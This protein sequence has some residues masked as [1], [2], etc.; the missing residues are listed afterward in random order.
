VTAANTVSTSSHE[1]LWV[2]L[3]ALLAASAVYFVRDLRRRATASHGDLREQ[4]QREE[5]LRE[6][7]KA[8]EGL[9]EMIVVVDRE[10]R[11]V[12]VNQAF[13]N[14]R[15]LEREQIIGRSVPEMVNRGVFETVIKEKLDECFRG[16]VV[17]F[18]MK[19]AYS[20]LGP[21]DLSLSYFPIEGPNGVERAVCVFQD[22]TERKRADQALHYLQDTLA[23]VRRI[24]ALGEL[25][26]SIAHEVNQPLA[27]VVTDNSAALHWLAAQPPNLDEARQALHRAIEEANRASGVIQRIRAL[28]R[29]APPQ[30]VPL[31]GN[32]VIQEVVLLAESELQRGGV[33]VKTELVAGLPNV[34][35]DRIQVQQV[36]L[37]LMLNAIEAMGMITD[38]PRELLIKS[39]EHPEGVLIQLRDSGQGLDPEL[40]GRVFEPFFTTK[41]AGIG[42]GLSISRS[43]I[44]AHGG[45]LWAAAA[46]PHGAIFQ[47]TLRGA[48][49][50]V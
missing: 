2:T 21:R 30:L 48:N 1:Y 46:H 45:R 50:A 6:Y 33:T 40:E 11:Y 22:I 14:Y 20:R 35:G 24:A 7:E 43:I 15:A 10:Y 44:E 41:P 47:F 31:D 42:L 36:V 16:K 49:S 25:T 12:L 28:L 18:E 34:L 5:R 19:Y 26:A 3:S 8:V 39:A 29:K 37:N 32:E 13:L 4:K 17:T 27:A 23:R 38:R 9:E